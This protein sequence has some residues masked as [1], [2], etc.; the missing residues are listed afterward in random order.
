VLSYERRTGSAA[1]CCVLWV[2]GT[3]VMETLAATTS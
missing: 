2:V 1:V 3:A